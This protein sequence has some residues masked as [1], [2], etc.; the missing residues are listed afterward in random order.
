MPQ[1]NSFRRPSNNADLTNI[2]TLPVIS[3]RDMYLKKLM[4][5]KE[6]PSNLSQDQIRSLFNKNFALIRDILDGI[7]RGKALNIGDVNGANNIL[8]PDGTDKRL[9]HVL[10][11]DELKK[12]WVATEFIGTQNR[13]VS[14]EAVK[15]GAK[16]QHIVDGNMDVGYNS[17]VVIEQGGELVVL[18]GE[19]TMS[20][21]YIIGVTDEIEITNPSMFLGVKYSENGGVTTVLINGVAISN[22]HTLQVGDILTA[23]GTN[24]EILIAIYLI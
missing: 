5:I 13:L 12:K 18:S 9:Q 15:I 22:G 11:W 21:S 20:L 7:L 6:A 10:K 14:G 1:D 3:P 19:S 4:N 23:E 2:T 17:E 24:G 8:F 16:H